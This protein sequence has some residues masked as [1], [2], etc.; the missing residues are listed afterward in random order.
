MVEIVGK[1]GH[2]RKLYIP[3]ANTW[4]IGTIQKKK[5]TDKLIINAISVLDIRNPFQGNGDPIP[6]FHLKFKKVDT[7]DDSVENKRYEKVYEELSAYVGKQTKIIFLEDQS[8]PDV[9]ALNRVLINIVKGD[10]TTI[11]YNFP[12]KYQLFSKF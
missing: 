7:G 10:G 5:Y 12:I 3:Q 1:S 6:H 9:P 11:H 4:F 8:T 2:D